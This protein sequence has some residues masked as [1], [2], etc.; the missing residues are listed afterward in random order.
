MEKKLH[1][2]EKSLPTILGKEIEDISGYVSA[3]YGEETLVFKISR[4]IF[5]DGTA[6]YVEGEHDMPYIPAKNNETWE[7]HYEPEED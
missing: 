4:I 3:E 2:W 7:E 1:D 5:K 6:F